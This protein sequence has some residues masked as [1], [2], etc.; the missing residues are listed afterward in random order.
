MQ[1]YKLFMGKKHNTIGKQIIGIIFFTIICPSI[2]FYWVVVKKYSDDLLQSAIKDRQNL[3]TAINRSL[4]LQFDITKELSMMIYYDKSVKEYIDNGDYSSIPN[5]V[6][7]SLESITNSYISVDSI[8]LCFKDNVYTYGKTF[9]NLNEIR[10]KYEGDIIK[11]KGKSIWLPTTIMQGA[12]ARKPKDYILS[13]AVNSKDGMVAIMYMFFSSDSLQKIIANPLLNKGGSSF[14]LL[15]SEGQVVVSKSEKEI[16]KKVN[17]KLPKENFDGNEGHFFI[18]DDSGSERLISYAKMTDPHWISVIIDK[19]SEILFD[20]NNI[21]KLAVIFTVFYLAVIL[22]G[23]IGIYIFIIRPIT[24]LSEGMDKVGNQEFSKLKIPYGGNEIKYLTE[25][26]N[27]M[28]GK[29]RELI[30]RVREEEAEKNEQRLKVLYMQIGPHFLYNTLN[31]IKWLAVLNKQDTIRQMIE[32]VMKIMN[33]VT[34]ESAQDM[35]TI[36][37]ELKLLDSYIYIQKVRFM[38]FDVYY[39]VPEEILNY[40]IDRFIL[41]PFVENSILHGIRDMQAG[42]AIRIVIRLHDEKSLQVDIYDNGKGIEKNEEIN[43]SR[44]RKDSIGIKNVR[45]RIYLHYGNNYGVVVENNPDKGVHV[46]LSLPAIRKEA[47]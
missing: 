46:K 44:E 15:S 45:E 20:V 4:S 37:H 16:G 27:Q 25:R 40:K 10:L 47:E 9:T 41:Q 26:F 17:I 21:T 29:I 36:E 31:S 8:L 24:R 5:N 42:G 22:L 13:R 14:Y 38:G 3:L 11:R 18:K 1:I 6:K 23:N 33:G 19:K 30:L 34:Y 28:S 32:S 43:W 39:D 12:F 7:E 2:I 35:I